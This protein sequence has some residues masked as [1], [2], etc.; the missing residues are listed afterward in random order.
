MK[1][2]LKSLA[3]TLIIASLPLMFLSL[4]WCFTFRGFDFI[5]VVNSIGYIL[6]SSLMLFV[7]IL[8]GGSHFIKED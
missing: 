2:I 1:H 5:S 4:L 8:L 3:I 7:G 6:L